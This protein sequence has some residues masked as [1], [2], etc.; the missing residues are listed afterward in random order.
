MRERLLA[1]RSIWL[2]GWGGALIKT[3]SV[4]RP[5]R[6]EDVRNLDGGRLF[7]NNGQSVDMITE[8]PVRTKHETPC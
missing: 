8:I 3:I 5:A 2:C 6:P 7:V 1:V 4:E